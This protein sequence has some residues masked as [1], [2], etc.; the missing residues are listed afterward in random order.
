M[1]VVLL[2]GGGEVVRGK[3]YIDCYDS[4]AFAKIVDC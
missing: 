3:L 2:L 1:V 4:Q